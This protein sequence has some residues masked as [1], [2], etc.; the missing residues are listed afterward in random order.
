MAALLFL[1]EIGD[2]ESSRVG[3]KA[4]SLARLKRL[5][6][7]VPDGFVLPADA[8]LEDEGLARALARLG[9]PVAVRSSSTAEDLAG[10]SF[11]G[12][13]ATVLGVSGALDVERAAQACRASAAGALDY[14]RTLG[15]ASGR[16]AVLVQRMVEPRVA[17]VAFGRSPHDPGQA[18]VEAVSGRGDRL[19]AGAAIPDRYG[20]DRETGARVAGP[21][22]GCLDAEDLRAVAG[23]V[24]RVEEALGSPQDVEWAI[25]PGRL[26]E[27]LALLQARPITTEVLEKPDPRIAPAHPR[28]HRRGPARPRHPAHLHHGG[29]L[30]RARV[31]L[32]ARPRRPAAPGRAARGRAAPAAP[33]PQLVAGSRRGGAAPRRV[34]RGRGADDPRRRSHGRGRAQGSSILAHGTRGRLAPPPHGPGQARRNRRRRSPRDRLAVPRGHSHRL[35]PGARHHLEAWAEVGRQVAATHVLTSGASAAALSVLA[36]ML[37][38]FARGP[39]AER[40]SRLT[41]GLLEVESA[42]PTLALEALAAGLALDPARL[43]WLA[44]EKPAGAGALDGAPADLRL[45]LEAFLS[46]FGHRAL[47][48]GELASPAWEDD[49][50]PVLLALRS[51]AARPG[52]ARFGAKAK[53]CLRRAEEESLLSRLPAL[54]RGLLSRGMASAQEGVRERE[55][56][57]S[58]TVAVACHGRRLAREAGARL[59][60]LA[61]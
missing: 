2:R 49:P 30:P 27:S 44:A 23:L 52:R 11:A 32:R 48:E 7:P 14:A 60:A 22:D 42:A 55:R 21:D 34:A 3:L 37:E 53:A 59:V 5:G 9:G 13:Y 61:S 28:Q 51:L 12:Q 18:L 38:A 54:P 31:P 45:E 39:A 33:L 50:T 4:A 1:D 24:R 47:S 29:S 40:A 57:K 58:L 25:G 16:M 35:N 15:A 56:T 20:L 26:P 10:A 17:G 43:R 41:A 19:L 8:E 46:R 6:F 36:R